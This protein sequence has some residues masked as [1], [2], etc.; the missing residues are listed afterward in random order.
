MSSKKEQYDGFRPYYDSPPVDKE[1]KPLR[2]ITMMPSTV[3]TIDF[4]LFDW[5]NEEMDIFCTTN[6]GWR[7]VPLIWSMPERA[8]QAKDNKDLRN[9]KNVFTLPAISIERASLIKDPN[10]KGVA[11]AHIPRQNDA[12][13]GAI[14]VARRIQQEKTSN[15]ANATSKRRFKQQTQPFNNNKVVYETITMPIP[16]Y[17]VAN[18]KVTI[19]TEYQQQMNEIFTP[20]MTYTGQI[21]NFFM[22]RDGHR[23]EGFIENDFA[24]ENNISNL[25]EEERNFKTV[26][27]LKVLGY[28]IGSAGN[29]NQPKITI[30]E[31]AAE[32]KFTRERVIL[33]DKKD[34]K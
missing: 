3:E 22:T 21:N 28:L 14:T 12:K 25:A 29:D 8:F 15:F 19:N 31:N 27:N 17:V 24:L 32:F 5:L 6:E 30:R 11:W 2:E 13:G 10:M 34:F 4:A 20:F 33:G 9:N 16:T 18:Y 1:K 7:K 26:V 23:F